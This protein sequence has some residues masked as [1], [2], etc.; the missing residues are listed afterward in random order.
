MNDQ[1]NM[2]PMTPRGGLPDPLDIPEHLQPPDPESAPGKILATARTLFA[3]RGLAATS[4]RAIAHRSGVNL[5]LIHYHFGNKEGLY[6]RVVEMEIVD[7]HRLLAEFFPGEVAPAEILPNIPRVTVRLHRE[8]PHLLQVMLRELA[9]GGPNLGE[10]LREL[11]SHGPHGLQ[12]LLR[13]LVEQG[14]RLGL[15]EGLDPAHVVAL[16]FC[17]G[18]GLAAFAPMLKEVLGLDMEQAETRQGVLDTL[19]VILRRALAPVKEG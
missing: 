17:L 11:G 13:G 14:Q 9:D 10:I 6:R 12:Q 2:N 16:L 19:E 8:H 5:A 15:A 4:T 7:L 1:N 18:N 3:E